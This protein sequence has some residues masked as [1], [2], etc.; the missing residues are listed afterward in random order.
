[1]SDHYNILRSIKNKDFV[2]LYMSYNIP[3]LGDIYTI[4][5]TT[6][7]HQQIH[8]FQDREETMKNTND[9]NKTTSARRTGT[10]ASAS[11]QQ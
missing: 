6:T 9:S 2:Y 8:L 7:L 4:I 10:C 3:I 5:P 1:M 11:I